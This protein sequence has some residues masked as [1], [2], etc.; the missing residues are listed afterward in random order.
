MTVF[1][2]SSLGFT[3]LCKETVTHH[4]LLSVFLSQKQNQPLWVTNTSLVSKQK[5]KRVTQS[6]LKFSQV[7]LFLP[8]ENIINQTMKINNGTS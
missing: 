1:A 6:S 7:L 4:V 3:P 5:V 8:S 2:L